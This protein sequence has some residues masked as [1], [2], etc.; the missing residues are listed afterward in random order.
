MC[1]FV[2][3]HF[4]FHFRDRT[5]GA[6]DGV[7]PSAQLWPRLNSL[8]CTCCPLC[9]CVCV[10]V[11]V[12]EK[13]SLKGDTNISIGDWLSIP[14]S[15]DY[16]RSISYV[17]P[18]G[19]EDGIQETRVEQHQ[20]YRC[21]GEIEGQENIVVECTKKFLDFPLGKHFVLEER[22]DIRPNLDRVCMSSRG[23]E[24]KRT[25]TAA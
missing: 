6:G 14:D 10:C 9:V 20:R 21:W 13:Y 8:S 16:E 25:T 12:C 7:Q 23:V 15:E 2:R 19:T 1:A 18:T 11:C 24:G 17:S 3:V 4:H 5:V 22:I